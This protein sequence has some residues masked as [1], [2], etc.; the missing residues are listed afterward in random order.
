[1]RFSGKSV[2]VVALLA[3]VSACATLKSWTGGDQEKLRVGTS[4]SYPPFTFS[5]G[6]RLKGIEVDFAKALTNE[7]GRPVE[8]FEVPFPNL[9]GELNAGR[10]DVIMT[11]MSVTPRR[12]ELVRFVEP[13]LEVGQMALI[14]K[15]DE[16]NFAGED[17]TR[18]RG[19]RVG[20]ER[21]TTGS[22]YVL[23]KLKQMEPVEFA[24]KEDGIAA[25]K[26]GKI[27]LFVHDAPF[28]WQVV[29]SPQNPNEELAGRFQ[30]L[31]D[32]KLA[33]AVRKDDS[34]LLAQLN[35]VV[36]RWKNSGAL[37]SVLD[38]WIRVRKVSR[39]VP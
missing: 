20:F 39:P 3:T 23:G 34:E 11:G 22:K 19:L 15:S 27:D 10:I 14:R 12:R 32:E 29:G 31:T 28:V 24:R 13:Y 36:E 17:W 30:L 35:A 16:N 7:I 21:G 37:D 33:W 4:G 9:I 6:R 1:M 26:Q 5:E 8:V 25:L 2:L 38:K 18:M